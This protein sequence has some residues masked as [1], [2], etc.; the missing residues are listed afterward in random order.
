[1]KDT[2]NKLRIDLDRQK[3]RTSV[4]ICKGD[5]LSRT[6]YITLLNSGCVF[7]IPDSA[8]ATLIATK[9][10]GKTV[11]NDCSI[12][13]NEISYTITNQ[14][15]AV[16]GDV[17]CQVKITSGE[18]IITSPVFI[19][20]VYE[21]LFDESILESSNDY[22]ALQ[23]YCARAENAAKVAEKKADNFIETEKTAFSA[24]N[25]ADSAAYMILTMNQVNDESIDTDT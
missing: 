8:I 16:A 2:V 25:I 21:R 15:I 11:Y 6:I 3:T 24:K 4:S 14:L 19:I 20:R 13:G 9:P 12:H 7:D 17:E 18:T 22:S 23:T 5:T 1:M 10:D